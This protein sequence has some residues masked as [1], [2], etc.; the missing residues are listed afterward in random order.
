[1]E[2]SK[3]RFVNS[4]RNLA[5][6]IISQMIQLALNFIVRTIFIYTLGIEYLGISGLFANILEVMS[7]ADLGFGTAI[8]YSLYKPISEE[9]TDKQAALMGFYKKIY[10]VIAIA[11]AVIG[12]AFVPFLKY[13]INLETEIPHIT[14]YYLLYLGNT[15]MSY[16]F[17]YKTSIVSAHQKSYLLN[18]YDSI[19]AVIQY[20]VQAILLMSFKNF[21]VYLVFQSICT[22]SINIYKARRSQSLYPYISQK[23]DLDTET[24]KDIG[25]NLLSMFVYKIGGVLLNNTDNI[26]ISVLVG[27]VAVG[28]YSNYKLLITAVT[29][30]TTIIFTSVSASVGN[31][32]VSTDKETQYFMFKIL[33]FI[34]FWV[35]SFCSIC[36]F[37]L[38]DPF[39]VF[40][41]GKEY[42]LSNAVVIAIILNFYL[43][44]TIY[45]VAIF[46]DTTGLFKQTKY[47]FLV[48][49]M[50]NLI[51]SIA[52]GNIWGLFGILIATTIARLLTNCWFEPY[53]LYKSYFD[54]PPS[55]Y[56]LEKIIDT[57]L[58]ILIALIMYG[59]KISLNEYTTVNFVIKMILCIILPNA[60][61][62]LLFRKKEEFK[63]IKNSV[64][65]HLV[66]RGRFKNI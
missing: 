1:M 64:Y 32:S 27:T 15:V 58:F 40:W 37:T 36:F 44:G 43:P 41:I 2:E 8:M 51:L 52:L 12:L 11:I 19:F 61:F 34:G 45:S 49:A 3:S 60:A 66:N 53:L 13:V 63:Y 16:L 14:L 55:K 21:T 26:L 22:L 17:V 18:I 48:T 25:T 33:D 10:S 65:A 59:V 20:T 54:V 24:K 57:I 5:T 38:M 6:G 30:F 9:D 39:I 46:R 7:I 62:L 56:F 4:S 29:V 28:Y 50:L 47:V 35:F 23:I 42:L 31:I